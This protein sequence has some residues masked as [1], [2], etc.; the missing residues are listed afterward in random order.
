ML[1]SDM[2]IEVADVAE[3]CQSKRFAHVILIKVDL[4]QNA[5]RECI[6]RSKRSC[7]ECD[8]NPKSEQALV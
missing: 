2:S 6:S 3:T 8:H 4:K 7:T 5:G 1:E